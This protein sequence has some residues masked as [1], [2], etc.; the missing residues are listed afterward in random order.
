MNIINSLP[1]KNIKNDKLLTTVWARIYIIIVGFIALL[2]FFLPEIGMTKK[3][4][5][6]IKKDINIPLTLIASITINLLFTILPIAIAKAG[7]V[8]I[9]IFNL[10][11]IVQF[12][13]HILFFNSKF[14]T[15]E[16]FGNIFYLGSVLFLAYANTLKN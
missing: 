9:A 6:E 1:N 13:F 7:P 16:V 8:S 10:N 11:F 14:N 4:F 12:I 3:L 2:S 5:N 15:Y